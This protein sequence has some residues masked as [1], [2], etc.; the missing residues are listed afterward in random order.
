MYVN[1][2][3]VVVFLKSDFD[4][5][6][7]YVYVHVY[8]YVYAKLFVCMYVCMYVCDFSM[9]ERFENWRQR[10]RCSK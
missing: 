6:F 9:V 4:Q 3:A 5:D 10:R 2:Y 7:E 1:N 8:V